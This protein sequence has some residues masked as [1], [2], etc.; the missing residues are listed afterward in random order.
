MEV[1]IKNNF[2]DRFRRGGSVLYTFRYLVNSTSKK[3]RKLIQQSR[4]GT[5]HCD[6]TGCV[7]A[8]PVVTL[9]PPREND[10]NLALNIDTPI[11]WI[12]KKVIS[13]G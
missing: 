2:Y 8:S 9:A 13:L 3:I 5:H 4:T 6:W 1:S 12:D 10:H 7:W 11:E